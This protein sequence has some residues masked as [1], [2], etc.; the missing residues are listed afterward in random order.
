VIILIP[1][2]LYRQGVNAVFTFWFAYTITRPFGASWADY[3]DMPIDQAGLNLGQIPTAIY[4]GLISLTLV[5]L[6]E[7]RRVGYPRSSVA[8]PAPEPGRAAV[9]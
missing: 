1:L 6:M 4:L 8:A 2:A 5:A 7:I 9:S 3:S